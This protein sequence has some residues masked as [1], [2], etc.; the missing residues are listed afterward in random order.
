MRRRSTWES[1][2]GRFATAAR[3]WRWLSR[4]MW[5]VFTNSGRA[6]KLPPWNRQIHGSCRGSSSPVTAQSWELSA[7]SI[8]NPPA[9]GHDA[10]RLGLAALAHGSTEA[11]G[12][13]S[14]HR[15]EHREGEGDKASSTSSL[16]F[17]HFLSLPLV[18]GFGP[19]ARFVAAE[20]NTT[21][22]HGGSRN[23]TNIPQN[24]GNLPLRD[25]S[26]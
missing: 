2:R 4:K 13:R 9:V 14:C 1:R 26:R 23:R 24:R 15:V 16:A 20:Q 3:S 18:Q 19:I 21:M 5:C 12:N 8:P 25:S 10:T 7:G 11:G 17:P 22:T 6:R